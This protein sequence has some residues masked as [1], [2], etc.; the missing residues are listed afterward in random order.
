ML[1]DATGCASPASR[2]RSARQAIIVCV[3][4][5]LVQ[6]GA[7][8]HFAGFQSMISGSRRAGGRYGWWLIAIGCMATQPSKS[9]RLRPR[10]PIDD[11]RLRDLF[12]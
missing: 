10:L 3:W 4:G 12:C 6:V 9:I 11:F 7:A 2:L 5:I 8:A 1:D